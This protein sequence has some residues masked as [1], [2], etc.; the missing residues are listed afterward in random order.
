MFSSKGGDLPRL[1]MTGPGHA[2]VALCVT[3][4]PADMKVSVLTVELGLKWT[5]LYLVSPYPRA[6]RLAHYH[7]PGAAGALLEI[8]RVEFSHLSE[9]AQDLGS[10]PYVGRVPNPAVVQCLAERRG[11]KLDAL[12]WELILGRWASEVGHG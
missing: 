10:V 12:G 9:V 7:E 8:E 11:W 5:V 3:D 6:V 1:I 2:G 4:D